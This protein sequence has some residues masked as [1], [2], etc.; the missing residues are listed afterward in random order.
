MG[1][2]LSNMANRSET[3]PIAEIIGMIMAAQAAGKDVISLAVGMPDPALL[4]NDKMPAIYQ[5]ASAKYPGLLNYT[6]PQGWPPLTAAMQKMLEAQGVKCSTDNILVTSGGMEALSM[7]AQLTLNEGDTVLVE[8]PA[9]PGAISTFKLLGANVVHVECDKDGMIPDRLK[10]AIQ[11]HK[12]KLVSLMPDFLNPSGATLSAERRPVIAKMLQES[13]V[14]GVEDAAYSQLCFDGEPLPPLQSFAP[15]HILYETSVSKIFAPAM[16]IGFLAVPDSVV[17]E[18]AAGIKSTYNMQASALNQAL[19][20]TFLDPET[21]YLADNLEKLRHAYR[22]RRD[23]MIGALE[24]YFPQGSGYSWN[25]P[26]GGMFLWFTAPEQVNLGE[27]LGKAIENGVAYVPGN[28]FYADASSGANAARLNFAS[29]PED[30]I[31][32]A[33][34]RFAVTIKGR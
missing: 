6:R 19:T 1:Y 12:P 9:F 22:A 13:G 31:D 2:G 21:G 30:K 8:S 33:I 3:E 18:K 27:L 10:E 16:R 14:L 28:M 4:P 11:A 24:K 5:A 29:T 25:K 26:R 20:E 23:V 15:D 17:F 34:R 32:E 7:A